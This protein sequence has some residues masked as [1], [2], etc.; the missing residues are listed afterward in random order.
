M[1][2]RRAA[3]VH[4]TH[5][6]FALLFQSLFV[7]LPLSCG[8]F[9]CL[10]RW[11]RCHVDQLMCLHSGFYFLCFAACPQVGRLMFESDHPCRHHEISDRAP[12]STLCR[13]LDKRRRLLLEQE[14]CLGSK[15]TTAKTQDLL[16]HARSERSRE[17]R[18]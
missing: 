15:E 5:A 10:L 14:I 3:M 16:A 2:V 1:H 11:Y 8:Y 13:E 18:R 12:N 6:T 9:F 17:R 7:I 4:F